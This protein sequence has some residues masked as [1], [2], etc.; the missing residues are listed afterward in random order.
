L[1]SYFG[2]KVWIKPLIVTDQPATRADV[3]ARLKFPNGE[4]AVLGDGK[5]AIHHLSYVELKEAMPR[6]NHYHKLRHE[7]FYLIS[8]D[9]EM[10]FEDIATKEQSG[11]LLRPGD[12]VY[13]KPEIA[14]VFVPRQEGHAI[15]YAAEIFDAADVY[16]Y[17]LQ[18]P[19][20]KAEV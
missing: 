17:P 19:D 7:Y 2:G 11:T 1:N 13:I 16:R 9:A 20:P 3:Q 4:L 10:V 14:H 8:G 5:T 18:K 6:G 15:E 12:L